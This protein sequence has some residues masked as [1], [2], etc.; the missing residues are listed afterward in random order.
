M[1]SLGNAWRR[2]LTA[3]KVSITAAAVMLIVTSAVSAQTPQSA[4]D[5][6]ASPVARATPVGV[7]T[8]DGVQTR[9]RDEGKPF[10]EGC[11][12]EFVV[13]LLTGFL[14]AFNRGDQEALARY[15]PSE[16][17]EF[18]PEIG[19]F[20]WYGV[21]GPPNSFNPGFTAMNRDELLVYFAERH[22]QHEQ[23]RLLQVEVGEEWHGLGMTLDIDRRADDIPHHEAGVKAAIDC[24]SE[25]IWVWGMGDRGILNDA[26]YTD[27]NATPGFG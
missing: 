19:K 20:N 2:H 18:P 24:P 4:A 15:F 8:I 14:D 25:T 11:G 21:G 22:D 12:V 26:L 13:D 5:P 23:M 9:V 7:R 3:M 17:A 6:G 1:P 27:P 10:A 16:V